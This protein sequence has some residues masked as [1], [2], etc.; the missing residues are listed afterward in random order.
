MQAPTPRQL[1]VLR[2]V[3]DF[4]RDKGYPPTKRELAKLLNVSSPTGVT[5]ILDAAE[6][7]GLVRLIPFI[8]R[9]IQ[10]TEAGLQA[11]NAS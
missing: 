3:R 7:K 1:E 8:S 6:Q 5:N 9:G 2:L 11:C 10:I 4:I